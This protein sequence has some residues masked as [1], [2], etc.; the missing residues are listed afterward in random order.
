VAAGVVVLVVVAMVYLAQSPPPAVESSAAPNIN[1]ALTRVPD[2]DVPGSDVAGLPRPRGATRSY[3]L[4]KGPVVTVIYAEHTGVAEV[5]R[6]LET[7]L[8]ASG[9]KSL[10]APASPHPVSDA[11]WQ[12]VF[13]KGAE[14]VQVEAFRTEDV[15]GVTYIVQ[16]PHS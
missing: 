10:A 2:R 12:A 5:R 7:T 6:E 16:N 8:A 4:D 3:Y 11:L 14:T 15:T 13:V 1:Q 9:W